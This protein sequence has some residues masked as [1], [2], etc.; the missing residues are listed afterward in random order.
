MT[1]ILHITT[2]DEWEQAIERG[3]Y[4][5]LSL[6]SEGFIHCSLQDQVAEVANARF[7]G[8]NDLILLWIDES[9]VR[10]EVRYEGDTEKYPHIYGPLNVDAVLKVAAYVPEPDGHFNTPRPEGLRI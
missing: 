7:A 3:E 8:R 5:S 1:T 6:E 10:P 9:R 2:L 4:S